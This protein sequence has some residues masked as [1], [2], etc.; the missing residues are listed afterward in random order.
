MTNAVLVLCSEAASPGKKKDQ[1]GIQRP[2]LLGGRNC[3]LLYLKPRCML[4]MF[5]LLRPGYS[6]ARPARGYS[7]NRF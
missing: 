3:I 6:T 5:P 7:Y 2:Q 4:R 1:K